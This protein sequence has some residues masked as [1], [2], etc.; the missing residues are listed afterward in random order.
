MLGEVMQSIGSAQG[1]FDTQRDSVGRLWRPPV[2]PP[3]LSGVAGQGLA[4]L[5]ALAIER[6]VLRERFQ[7]ALSKASSGLGSGSDLSVVLAFTAA[8]RKATTPPRRTRELAWRREHQDLLSSVAGQWVV[9]EGDQL[10]A[11]GPDPAAL[12]AEARA[13]GIR[14]PYVFFVEAHTDDVVSLGL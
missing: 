1:R 8:T 13:T 10:V 9:L 4:T 14:V 5:D 11:H 3:G 12:I 6:E 2:A 7:C